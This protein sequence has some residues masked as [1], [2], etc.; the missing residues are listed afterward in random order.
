MTSTVPL[1]DWTEIRWPEIA[2]G[3]PARWIA[4]L[5]LAAT[6]QHGPHLPVG[7]D[8]MIAEAY[9]ALVRELLPVSLPATFLPM[10]PVGISTEHIDFPGTLTL[11]ADVALKTWMALGES[12]ARAG[13]KKLV[14]VTSHGGNSAAMSLVAQDLR[15]Q[16]GM[17]VVT[18]S[19][20]RLSAAEE[21]FDA[22]EVRH[23]IHGG[24]VETSIMLARYPHTVRKEAIADFHPASIAI[25]KDHRWLSTQRPAPFAWQTQDLH[26]SGAVGDATKASAE[27]GERLLDHGARAFCELLADVDN[28]DVNRLAA[29]PR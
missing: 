14:M 8:I 18:T 29:G 13:V 7:T 3:E 15:A 27:K 22:E 26:A 4:V 16:H 25:E 21:L 1:R 28:F 23:G 6:E 24:A 9:L 2:A 5:P 12:V 11:P 17:L 10:Q 19:W 20:S